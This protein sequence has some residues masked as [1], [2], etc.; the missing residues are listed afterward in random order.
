MLN[1]HHFGQLRAYQQVRIV[2]WQ[3]RQNVRRLTGSVRLLV[4]NKLDGMVVFAVI[5]RIG[6]CILA[7][8]D[9]QIATD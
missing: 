8:R 9:P 6:P 3:N 1:R 4:G 7:V 5:R 2:S